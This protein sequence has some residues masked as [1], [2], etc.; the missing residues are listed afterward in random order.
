L[1][2]RTRVFWPLLITVLLADCTTKRVAVETLSP[3]EPQEVI[4][5]AFRFNL[6][7]NRSAAMGLPAGEYGK[8]ALGILSLIVAAG[9]GIWY[10]RS[11]PGDVL[12]SGA[13]ALVIAGALGNAWER[14]FS[15]RGVVDF[16]DI[17]MG[18][19]RF[20]TF[21]IADVAITAGACLLAVALWRK[22][23]KA[24]AHSSEEGG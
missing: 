5:E 20:W 8:E 17:G 6:T 15:P 9:L 14:L 13:S 18:A 12:L 16:I 4:G 3:G 2:K 7:F 24:V 23:G 19:L 1:L 10:R 22:D 21:N 11:A